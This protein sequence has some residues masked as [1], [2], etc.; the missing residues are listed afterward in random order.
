MTKKELTPKEAQILQR[1]QQ[2]MQLYL[3]GYTRA[4]IAQQ[5]NVSVRQI[6]RDLTEVR[7]EVNE[8]VSQS[9]KQELIADH[10]A[11]MKERKR[12]LWA[13]VNDKK[14]GINRRQPFRS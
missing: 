6:A 4:Q 13:Q 12:Q 7:K 10:V 9:Q 8:Q 5:M 14:V 2:V 11:E 1:R 3:Y